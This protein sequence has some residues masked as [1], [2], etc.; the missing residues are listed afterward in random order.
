MSCLSS[1][2]ACAMLH[3]CHKTNQ[4]DR[5]EARRIASVCI[6]PAKGRTTDVVRVLGRDRG[7]SRKK[8]VR[9][10]G[11]GQVRWIDDK[12]IMLATQ[13]MDVPVAAAQIARSD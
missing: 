4:P 1:C 5:H 3:E 7:M 12:T 8:A 2:L 10:A 13:S 6:N 11:M 9:L